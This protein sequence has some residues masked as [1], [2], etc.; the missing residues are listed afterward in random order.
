MINALETYSF[1]APWAAIDDDGSG[2]VSELE[3]ELPKNHTLSGGTFRAVARRHDCD[4]VLFL[5]ERGEKQELAI[6]HL[7][8]TGLRESD[9][10]YPATEVFK[11]M[12]ELIKKRLEPDA[13]EFAPH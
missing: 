12:E 13:N 9:P 4:D 6:V 8:W 5:V 3:K 1:Q 10:Y 11:S 7:T 2:L